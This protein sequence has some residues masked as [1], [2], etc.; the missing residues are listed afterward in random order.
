MILS[1]SP[2]WAKSPAPHNQGYELVTGQGQVHHWKLSF[3]KGSSLLKVMPLPRGCPQLMAGW[4]EDIKTWSLAFTWVHRDHWPWFGM[5]LKGQPNSTVPC[6]ISSVLSCNHI[7]DSFSFCS[8]MHFLLPRRH[9]FQEF[10][11]CKSS[12]FNCLSYRLFQGTRFRAVITPILIHTEVMLV[13]VPG[14]SWKSQASYPNF[15]TSNQFV[16][17]STIILAFVLYSNTTPGNRITFPISLPL[18]CNATKRRCIL[19]DEVICPSEVSNKFLSRI[20]KKSVFNDTIY[21]KLMHEFIIFLSTY[22]Y[23]T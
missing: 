1:G 6:W 11:S 18:S 9:I 21:S 7:V 3:T 15:L 12:A 19:T 22:Q 14:G 5:C 10:L 8:E 13:R 2:F 17:C 23:Y 20:F 16:F 4:D